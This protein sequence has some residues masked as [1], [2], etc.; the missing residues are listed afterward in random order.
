MKKNNS[1]D[2]TNPKLIKAFG[3]DAVSKF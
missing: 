3:K 1:I 2:F